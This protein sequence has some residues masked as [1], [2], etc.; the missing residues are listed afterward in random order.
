MPPIPNEVDLLNALKS[1]VLDPELGVNIVDL[2][3][4]E[5]LEIKPDAIC[6]DLIMTTPTCPQGHAL[7]DDA[8][9]VLE[10]LLPQ[11]PIQTQLVDHPLWTPD[12]MT[13]AARR[14]LGWK[15]AS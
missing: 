14:Q 10:K 1:K 5:R 15:E 8:R 12:R 11:I 3:L 7:L 4:V 13:D 2:G 9:R 6:L